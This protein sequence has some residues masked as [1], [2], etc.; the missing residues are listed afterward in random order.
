M[1]IGCVSERNVKFD[2]SQFAPFAGSGTGAITGQAFLKTR[3]GDVKFGA[4]NKVVLFPST[5]FTEEDYTRVVINSEHL[6]DPLPD[7]LRAM[8]PYLH[9]TVADGSGHF[10]FK[11][12]PPGQYIVECAILWEV[13]AGYGTS[14]TGGVA[15]S[16]ATVRSG[17]TTSVVATR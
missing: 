5:D 10:E 14:Q 12:L 8:V 1:G 9:M 13:A 2:E 4:G 17:E 7:D 3:G 16:R 11:S 15:H 6:K